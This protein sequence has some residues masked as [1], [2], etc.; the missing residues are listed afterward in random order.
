MKNSAQNQFVYTPATPQQ[1]AS[2][3]RDFF[4]D[5]A[6]HAYTA[7]MLRGTKRA[8]VDLQDEDMFD[9]VK[10]DVIF[11]KLVADVLQKRYRN[12]LRAE[13]AGYTNAMGYD[14]LD[15]DTG[16]YVELK[17]YAISRRGGDKA[18]KLSAMIS[19]LT[20]KFCTVVALVI[21]KDL[22][23]G[24]YQLYAIP[25]QAIPSDS[26]DYLDIQHHRLDNSGRFMVGTTLERIGGG[27]IAPYA[28]DSLDDLL[29]M[30]DMMRS[31]N[32][33]KLAKVIV[34]LENSAVINAT[35]KLELEHLR[36]LFTKSVRAGSVGW[37]KSTYKDLL[38][39]SLDWNDP[40]YRI[41]E[42]NASRIFFDGNKFEFVDWPKKVQPK[43]KVQ[44]NKRVEKIT[45][46]KANK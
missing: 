16:V 24:N 4:R 11:E 36:D 39:P 45:K 29:H 13:D 30:D 28:I 8:I 6:K 14:I 15:T 17:D 12:I 27:T 25:P 33:K 43:P 35:Q 21:D 40:M 37:A 2:C 32:L 22:P 31:V 18:P 34:D 7:G 9:Q 20:N 1:A 41:E 19:N 10:T 38:K 3:R 42:G 26:S 44:Q 5:N 46:E 23:E